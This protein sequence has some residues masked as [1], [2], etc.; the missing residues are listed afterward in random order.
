MSTLAF[1]SGQ[2]RLILS[3]LQNPPPSPKTSKRMAND[4]HIY[5]DALGFDYEISNR[6]HTKDPKKKSPTDREALQS[7]IE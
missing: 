6:V 5:S 7:P 4:S 1:I 3:L 2:H